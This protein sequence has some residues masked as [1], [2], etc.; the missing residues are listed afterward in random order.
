MIALIL[1]I[2]LIFAIVLV[3]GANGLIATEGVGFERDLA[4]ISGL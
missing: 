4:Y 3:T 2:E 1:T